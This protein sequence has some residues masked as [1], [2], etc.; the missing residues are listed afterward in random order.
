MKYGYNLFSAYTIIQNGKDL[1]EVM[2]ALKEMGYDGVE[3]FLPYDLTAAELKAAA[4][5]IGIEVFSTHPRLYRF[6][7]NLDEEIAFAQEVGIQTLV[8]PHV[9][10]ENREKAYYQKVLASIPQWKR[11]CAEAGLK[12]A[13]HNHDFEFQPYD[14]RPFLMD[15]ILAAD[16]DIRYEIDTFWTTYAGIDTLA[17]MERYKDRIEYVHFKDYAGKTGPGYMD[18]D[19]CAVGEGLVDVPAVANK[20]AQIGVQWAV[21]EQDLHKKDV[22]EDARNSLQT[23]RSLLDAPAP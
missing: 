16:P 2:R 19:F 5:E 7:E 4:E 10:D 23:L 12:L 13:W 1:V 8:M 14:G 15:A 21:V 22:L 9:T 20:A 6:F 3:L 18:I 17:Y 11:R